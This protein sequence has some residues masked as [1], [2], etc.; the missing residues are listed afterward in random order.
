MKPFLFY[1]VLFF[2]ILI[3]LTLVTD[4]GTI[5]VILTITLLVKYIC[6][7][8]SIKATD[9]CHRTNDRQHNEKETAINTQGFQQQNEEEN[10][11]SKNIVESNR[12]T[13]DSIYDNQYDTADDKIFNASLVSGG[14]EKKAKEIRS[15]WNNEN[16]KK[17]Y[18]Y[19]LFV[20]EDKNRKWWTEDDYELSKKH[21][22]F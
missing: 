11:L 3:L 7:T 12:N 19:E 4:I 18:D 16:L 21:V 10:V 6:Q 2:V 9:S 17:Y 15:H 5:S 22:V 20:H 8:Y 13:L 1:T 14:K